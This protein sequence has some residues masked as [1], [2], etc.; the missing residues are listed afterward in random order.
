MKGATDH[1]GGRLAR[2]YTLP[3]CLATDGT[4]A[5]GF[6]AS[7]SERRSASAVLDPTAVVFLF[8]ELEA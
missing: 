6:E 5:V 8:Y 7:F 2:G 3:R 4:T 1:I